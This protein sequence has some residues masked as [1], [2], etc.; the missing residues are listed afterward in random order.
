MLQPGT[1][2]APSGHELPGGWIGFASALAGVLGQMGKGQFLVIESPRRGRYIQFACGGPEGLRFEAVSNAFLADGDRLA[3]DQ[4]EGLAALG[5]HPPTHRP[6]APETERVSGGSVNHYMDFE[7]PL[8][9][10]EIAER[11]IGT[12]TRIFGVD[13]P[14]E[15]EYDAFEADGSALDHADL[16]LTRR[17]RAASRD[18]GDEAITGGARNAAEWTLLK[19]MRAISAMPDL[20]LDEDGDIGLTAYGNLLYL[21]SQGQGRW[22]QFWAP[23]LREVDESLDLWRKLNELNA[24]IGIGLRVVKRMVVAEYEFVAQPF[25]QDLLVTSL[26]HFATSVTGIDLLLHREFGGL[27]VNRHTHDEAGSRAE[28]H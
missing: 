2:T 19:A 1:T 9:L 16:G 22:I 14:E 13:D 15:L 20:Q 4:L 8:P 7:M 11:A 24:M 6:D 21:R 3:N 27:L 17:S 23:L 5:W 18:L 10:A 12:L 25:V 26:Q 28:P